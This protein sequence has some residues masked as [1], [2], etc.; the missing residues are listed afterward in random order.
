MGTEI[1]PF[2]GSLDGAGFVIS[3][4]TMNGQQNMGLFGVTQGAKLFNLTLK[5]F[6]IG[7]DA[8]VGA[9]VGYA[10]A[11][12][13][14]SQIAVIDGYINGYANVGGLVGSLNHA[15]SI[16]NSYSIAPVQGTLN[17]G[18]LVGEANQESIL[19]NT[20]AAGRVLGDIHV[21]GLLGKNTFS[22]V[23]Q[24][25]FDWQTTGQN[26]SAGGEHK[27]TAEM[28]QA[29]TYANWDFTTIWDITNGSTYPRLR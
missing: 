10:N 3:N 19:Q 1:T 21:G 4:V 25:Y 8:Q 9:L 14:I 29:T 18:G 28:M 7:G 27:N 23:S 16:T 24:S 5:N 15:S 11:Q 6:H 2:T 13:D 20:Y 17:V 26:N 22:I 12:S